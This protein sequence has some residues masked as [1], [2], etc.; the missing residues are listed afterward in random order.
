MKIKL[1]FSAGDISRSAYCDLSE[2]TVRRMMDK[3]AKR[4]VVRR[5]GACLTTRLVNVNGLKEVFK[6]FGLTEIE[7]DE[8]VEHVIRRKSG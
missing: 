2:R 8:A 3:L 5:H 6:K 1:F 4:F 7:L